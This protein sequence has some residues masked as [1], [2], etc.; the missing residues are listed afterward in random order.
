[1]GQEGGD[2]CSSNRIPCC[3]TRGSA[4]AQ[5]WRHPPSGS[6]GKR[7]R[8]YY[9]TQ[10]GIKPPTFVLFCNDAKLFP[11]DYKKF[12][13][14][15][16]RCGAVVVRMVRECSAGCRSCGGEVVRWRWCC[17]VDGSRAPPLE[18]GGLRGWH[19]RSVQA[20]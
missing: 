4:R 1:M 13:E 10:A 8:I 11:D 19:S 15:Q 20:E 7:G 9:G 5:G 3:A 18:G 16:F 2:C 12:M 14:R 17:G 6:G